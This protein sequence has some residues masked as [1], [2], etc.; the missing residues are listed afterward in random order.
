MQAGFGRTG[1]FFGYE[2]YN[3]IPDI[4]CV[5]KGM[6]WTPLSGVLSSKKYLIYLKLEV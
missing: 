4:I 2:N 5:G 1:K 6:G 3:I